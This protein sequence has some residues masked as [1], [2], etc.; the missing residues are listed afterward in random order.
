MNKKVESIAQ[1][2]LDKLP[3]KTTE[4]C[5]FDPLTIILIISVLLTLVRVIQECR[6]KRTLLK[7]KREYAS[8][9]KRDIQDLVLKD[10]WLNNLRLNKILKKNLDSKQY[11]AYAQDL[12]Q[13]IMDVGVNL[14][15]DELIN[16]M[17][18][19]ND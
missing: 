11:K 17:E 5:G 13:A 8:C 4:N 9:V 3:S 7:D 15:E 6:K 18:A 16:L 2:V 14:T 10:S 19:A 12:K 1:K